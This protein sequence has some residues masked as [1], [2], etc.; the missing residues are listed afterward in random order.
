MTQSFKKNSA[1]VKAGKILASNARHIMLYGGSRSSKTFTLVRAILIRAMKVKSR[2]MILR[3]HFNHVKTSIWLDT[4]P[5]V[6]QV[7]FP[8]LVHTFIQSDHY[9]KLENGSE[10]WIGGLDDQKNVEK[11]LGKEYSTIFFNECSQIPYGSVNVAVT[12]L[13]ERNELI[14]KAYYDMNPPKKSHWTYEKFIKF[15]DPKD[16]V[17]IDKDDI[18]SMLMNPHDNLDNIDPDYITGIL[19]K[20]SDKDKDR[21]LYGKFG[22]DS[23]GQAYYSFVREIHVKEFDKSMCVGSTLIGL[24]FNVNPMTAVICYFVNGCFYVW[25]EKFLENSDTH[26]MCKNLIDSGY[27]GAKLYPDSTG[28]NRKTS[29]TSDFE[30]LKSRG[31]TIEF[32]RNPLQVD[33][34]NNKNRLLQHNKI[35]IH[36]RCRKLIVDLEK[37]AWKNGELD[38]GTDKMLT[39]IS[40]SLGYVTWAI[41]PLKEKT[42]KPTTIQL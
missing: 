5:R 17:P 35:I 26:K 27:V 19:E 33:R 39:H 2:H 8:S 1:Q 4:L 21:F 7:C 20:M 18:A 6:I 24:D 28:S 11:I 25:D 3:L 40:D 14:K 15:I 29:G 9:L 37:V 30:I 31:F 16:Q 23:D 13:A 38:K 22:E 10:I 42:K 36:P 32:T 41:D 34:V 12:R